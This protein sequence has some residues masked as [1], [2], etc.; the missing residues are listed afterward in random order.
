MSNSSALL[1]LGLVTAA[2]MA[3]PYLLPT[4]GSRQVQD[5]LSGE[6]SP[7]TPANLAEAPGQDAFPGAD[8]FGRYARGGRGGT[9]IPVTTLADRGPGSL[10]AC[11][12]ATMPRVCIFRVGGV[13][14]FSTTRPIIRNPFITI[15]GQ[16][17]PGGGI[18]I[19]HGGGPMGFTPIV[20]K[21]T[22]DVVI[23]HIRV[24]TDLNGQ[25]RGSNGAFL[26]EH[27][28]DVIFDHVSGA[29][30]LDQIMSG[31]GVNDNITVSNSIFTQGIPRHDKCALLGSHPR[32]A[33]R[34]S[35]T[36]N[37]CA[38]NGD[39]NP[40]VNFPPGSCIE[41]INNV[42]YNA[43][44]EFAEIHELDGGTPVSLIA[45]VFRKGPNTRSDI[46]AVTRVLLGS[47]GG[48]RVYL[49]GNR[50]DGVRNLMTLP[51]RTSLV[52]KPVCPVQSRV[53]S[54]NSAYQEVL[55][56]AGAFPR[57]DLDLRTVREVRE[58]SG[59]ILSDAA[60]VKGPRPLPPIA[61]GKPYADADGDGMSDEWEKAN[62][63]DVQRRDMWED[64]DRDGWANLNEFLDFAHREVLAGRALH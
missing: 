29:W 3:A 37:I 39:R 13:I 44:S 46:A 61:P 11:I 64:R 59:Q 23:R 30:S 5:E 45:N 63:L 15:A 6:E 20:V 40:D 18:L 42:L 4:Q 33:Q 54:A 36:R 1:L 34:I 27:S 10:R 31:Y 26:F 35:F 50:L 60:F 55:G 47:T 32:H 22:H 14:R 41:I 9:I 28:H 17:A 62:G 19:T 16:T 7:P 2:M 56:K 52:A 25:Q 8:G 21:E 49:S 38:H 43:E 12:E 53:M 58:Q 57:D 24:R 48:S 51:V